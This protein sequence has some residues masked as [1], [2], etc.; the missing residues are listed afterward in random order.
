MDR[1]V[2]A[3]NVRESL[4]FFSNVDI[5]ILLFTESCMDPPHHSHSHTCIAT[6]FDFIHMQNRVYKHISSAFNVAEWSEATGLDCKG[7]L[8]RVAVKIYLLAS[9]S[10]QFG[11]VHTN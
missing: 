9:R 5:M 4:Y 8:V 10:S 3:L 7:S 11:K 1:C 6:R 2:L